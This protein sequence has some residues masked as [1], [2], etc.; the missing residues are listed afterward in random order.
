MTHTRISAFAAVLSLLFVTLPVNGAA[1]EGS[2]EQT[3]TVKCA[4]CH[5]TSRVCRA[6][7]VK[8][9]SAWKS[10][11]DRMVDKGLVLS[12]TERQE[13][14]NYLAGDEA[15]KAGFCGE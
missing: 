9:G 7:G 1:D 2:P 13:V 14:V 6:I 12:D 3:V 8:D 5:S 15:S 4:Y 10:T 11:V